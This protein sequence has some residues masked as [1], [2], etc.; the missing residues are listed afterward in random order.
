MP[1]QLF[2]PSHGQGAVQSALTAIL[3]LKALLPQLRSA[4]P[5]S[6]MSTPL[7]HP[8]FRICKALRQVFFPKPCGICHQHCFMPNISLVLFPSQTSIL[9]KPGYTRHGCP[10][11]V[12]P[13]NNQALF[14]VLSCCRSL[15]QCFILIPPPLPAIRIP[16]WGPYTPYVPT[17][18]KRLPAC[19][20]RFLCP[21]DWD[22]SI[23]NGIPVLQ[24]SEFPQR[25]NI[26][27]DI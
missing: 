25:Q 14:S 27:K 24:S 1:S 21:A 20:Y 22:A 12:C 8:A 19:Q 5:Q 16:S 6:G 7:W 2:R 15:D 17:W 9:S 11:P 4:Y 18:R 26:P 23:I 3:F 13:A 10:P